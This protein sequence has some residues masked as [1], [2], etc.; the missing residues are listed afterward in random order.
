MHKNLAPPIPTRSATVGR[1]YRLEKLLGTGAAGTVY[2]AVDK[3]NGD[4]VALKRI[5][6]PT[7]PA[8]RLLL[9]REFQVLASLHHPNIIGVRDYGFDATGQTFFT[10]DY[11]PR[12]QTF[13]QAGMGQHDAV[14][15]NLFAQLLRALAYI[16]RRNVIHRDLKPNNVL[17]CR[18]QLKVLD[19][20]LAL[21][22][23]QQGR[24]SGSL[25]Y[26]APEV[27]ENTSARTTADLYAAGIMAYE[28]FAGH[29]PFDMNDMSRLIDAI[30]EQPPDLSE[31]SPKVA[32]VIGRLLA[33]DPDAR[34]P[35]ARAA[36]EALAQTA[37]VK[38]ALETQ[39]TR[40]SF[41]Q[42]ADFVGRAEELEQ[43]QTALVEVQT[44]RGSAWLVGGE[45]GVGKSRLLT[46][47][48]TRALVQGALVLRGQAVH[49]GRQP[50]HLWRD[51]ARWL[52]VLAQP[53]D[54]QAGALR[55]L[56]PDVENLL[57][58]TIPPAPALDPQASQARMLAVLTA[59]FR[60]A[61]EQAPLVLLLDDVQWAGDNSLA[62]L[63]HVTRLSED[64]ALLVVA[65]YQSDERPGLPDL[66]PGMTPLHLARL[67]P[68]AI[69]ALS[70]SMLGE[71]GQREEIVSFLEQ[72]TEGNTFFIVEVVRAL[73]EEAGQLDKVGDMPLPEQVFAGGIHDV[74]TRRIDRVPIEALPLLELAAVAGR[75][76]DLALLRALAPGKDVN[77]WLNAC[78][79]AA[80][81]DASEVH[82]QFAHNKL[83]DALLET[84]F[85][86]KRARLHRRVA[87]TIKFL[88]A[89]DL[90]THAARLAHHYRQ[91]GLHKQEYRYALRAGKLAASQYANAEALDYLN[92]VLELS[93]TLP[94]AGTRMTQEERYAALLSRINVLHLMGRRAEEAA[95]LEELAALAERLD[96]DRRRAEAAYHRAEYAECTGD[97]TTVISF[98]QT[99][100]ALATSDATAIE[101]EL[102]SQR[103]LGTILGRQGHLD[104]A[105]ALLQQLLPRATAFP[106]IQAA[107]LRELGS[108][109]S[110]QGNVAAASNCCKR[111]LQIYRQIG[112][113]YN[114]S[115]ALFNL[116]VLYFRDS[117]YDRAREN[118]ELAVATFREINF[119]RGIGVAYHNMG[120]LALQELDYLK[121]LEVFDR[122]LVIRREIN[123]RYGEALTLL[124]KGETLKSMGLFTRARRT[125]EAAR[126]IYR[127]IEVQQGVC[128]AL[129]NL[130]DLFLAAGDPKQASAYATQALKLAEEIG[131]QQ[132]I[133]NS[134]FIL[135]RAQL[136]RG[137]PDE[138]LAS[139][140]RSISI[141][142]QMSLIGNEVQ[143]RAA[144]IETLL[145]RGDRARALAEAETLL[146]HW[147]RANL[148]SDF[149]P[150][151]VY[152]ICYRVLHL[153]GDPR[154][155]GILEEACT[156]LEEKAAL[157]PEGELREAFLQ[158]TFGRQA[159]LDIRKNT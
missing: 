88:Y 3:L 73:A 72:E 106:S 102:Q 43:L 67:A 108:V 158:G 110:E 90:D 159:L 50:Y 29:Y 82:W 100:A 40:E 77:A 68:E 8:Q 17:V 93:A 33:K 121:A 65:G 1:R 38:I 87:E 42:A 69:A 120:N 12:A 130:G 53:D 19:F 119:R 7:D 131:A 76:L 154:A 16:H 13:L 44:G 47:V 116:G 114:E 23:G 57:D 59:M 136:A 6:N 55:L 49:E 155:E 81:L 84:I 74:V 52:S 21:E 75:E 157:L 45:S 48:R 94:T 96:S 109:L 51:V 37:N 28:L 118:Y 153:Q 11:L 10:M 151:Y 86:A 149:E 141:L 83:R 61:S 95:D 97:Y 105:L 142:N 112:D 124:N 39:A 123:D 56:L 62:V 2:R 103:L 66:L 98:A 36:L 147:T 18:G 134:L 70:T 41:L 152:W 5:L 4:V 140:N 113:R 46:E 35:T 32:P 150:F 15:L 126:E 91:A 125:L 78:A 104:E 58:R 117:V 127:E 107:T 20:G 133:A 25:V 80:V 64:L 115:K 24:S 22:S 145:V 60:R 135:G 146:S 9:A 156:L 111:A 31:L 30:L 99:A 27:L 63:Q 144:L 139:T 79:N 26:M 101:V 85:P 14:K 148:M 71:T 143:A 128:Y 34:Y 54:I 138:A 92:R 132:V 122:A 137:D 89:G 129:Y